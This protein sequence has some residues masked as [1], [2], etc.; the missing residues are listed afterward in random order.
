MSLYQWT[1]GKISCWYATFFSP[2]KHSM[3]LYT[4]EM[5]RAVFLGNTHK[6]SLQWIVQCVRERERERERKDVDK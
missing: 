3:Y 2:L 4:V 5:L 1:A 6:R